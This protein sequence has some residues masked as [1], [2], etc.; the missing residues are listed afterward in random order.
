M[1]KDGDKILGATLVGGPAGD[2]IT[3]VTQAMHNG[4]GL[5]DLGACVHPYPSYAECIKALADGYN[6]SKIGPAEKSLVPGVNEF[7]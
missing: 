7:K 5:K 3:N 2:I 1:E 6:R 4:I